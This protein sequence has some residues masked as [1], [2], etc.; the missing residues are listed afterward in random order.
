MTMQ[1]TLTENVYKIDMGYKM[2]KLGY[3]AREIADLV[4][5][6][7]RTIYRWRQKIR[8]KGIRKF[9]KEYVHNLRIRGRSGPSEVLKTKVWNI[10]KEYRHCCGEKIWYLLGHLRSVSTIYRI[11]RE[12]FQLKGKQ[13]RPQYRGPLRKGRYPREAVQVDAVDLGELY[14][15]TAIDT[16]TREAHVSIQTSCDSKAAVAAL[17]ELNEAFGFIEHLQKDG[18]AEFETDWE[19]VARSLG[20]ELRT[21]APYQKNEQAFIERFNRSLREECLG[22]G[23][24]RIEQIREVQ[25]RADDFVRYYHYHRPHLSLNFATPISFLQYHP[26]HFY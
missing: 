24:Y 6:S 12:G 13:K 17:R 5:R 26:C 15:F 23:K 4:D 14:A 1:T 21:S 22:S 8:R 20:A 11:L 7:V 18:G 2:T 25:K 19:T 10:R 9:R 16:H 3:S